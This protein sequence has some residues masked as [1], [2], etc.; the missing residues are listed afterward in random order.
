MARIQRGV[1]LVLSAANE[2]SAS[3]KEQD[4]ANQHIARNVEGIKQK[5]EETSV[6][7]RNV[8]ES[9][10]QLESLARSMG[11]SVHRFRV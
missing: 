3:L 4:L 11:D 9:A 10:D 1:D 6:V 2:I 7:V 5:T 8:A